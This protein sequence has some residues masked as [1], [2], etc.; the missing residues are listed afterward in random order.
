TG[1]RWTS[2]AA[3][4]FTAQPATGVKVWAKGYWFW[5]AESRDAWRNAGGGVLGRDLTGRSGRDVGAELDVGIN[6]DL[7][8]HLG[9]QA[10][11]SLFSGGDFMESTRRTNDGLSQF[12]YA[13]FKFK[14]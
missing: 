13:Q 11:Y 10:G 5:L 12:L 9:L 2:C 1:A 7:N 6:A 8:K 4:G 3:V 14:F